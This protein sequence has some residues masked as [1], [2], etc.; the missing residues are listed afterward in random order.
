MNT[1]S[2]EQSLVMI[3][4][5]QERLVAALD[6]DI[7]VSKAVKIA[8][9]A[10][11]LGIPIVVTEQY[12]KGLGNTVPQLKETL[13][14]NTDIIEKTSFNALLE[15]GMSEKIASYGKK[16]IVLFGIETHICVH[17]TAA[18]L[19]EAGYEVYII[20]DACASRNKY[21]FKQGIDI[22]QQNGAKIS[23]V[24]IAL[25]EWLKG[26][27]NPKFKEVQALIK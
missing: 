14:A 27:K 8:S 11:S 19:L 12:P 9:A 5:I 15:E 18:A 26:A 22:M 16:Q 1:L 3:I 13:P 6:K 4:D 7:V 21:E 25:F 10:K 24:E 20:K 2:A 17:Q 23:C